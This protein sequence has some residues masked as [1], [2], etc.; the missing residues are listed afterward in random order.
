MGNIVVIGA[1]IGGIA[2]ALRLAAAGHAVTVVEADA[3][4][5][6][7]ARHVHVAGRPVDGGPTVFTLRW[8][9]DELL[10]TCGHDPDSV[11]AAEPVDL[12][13]RHAWTGGGELDLH[14]DPERSAAAI[15]NLAGTA[16]AARFR[17]FCARARKVYATLERS[18]MAAPRPSMPGLVWRVGLRGLPGLMAASPFVSMWKALGEHFHDPR[19]RQLFGRYA[20]YCGSSP[21]Q[22]PSTL[23]LVAHA[24][25]LGVWA[26]RDGM[27]GFAQRLAACAEASGARFRYGAAVSRIEVAHGRAAAVVLDDGARI[28]ADAVIANADPAAIAHGHFGEA[29]RGAVDAVPA[30]RRSLSAYVWCIAGRARGFPLARHTVFFSTDYRAEFDA[31]FGHGTLPAEP[32]VYAWAADRRDDGS[33]P[34]RDERLMFLANAPAATANPT[35]AHTHAPLCAPPHGA[36]AVGTDATCA[37]YRDRVFSLLARCGLAVD[38]DDE[39]C[40]VTTPQDFARRFPGS[41]GALYGQPTHGWRASFSRGGTRTRLP[42]LYLAGGGVHPGAG[43]PMVA[44][45]GRLAAEAVIADLERRR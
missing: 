5:G 4:P 6:G 41:A 34:D 38:H 39:S 42:G 26:P 23:M 45:S 40:V 9:F 33:A 17:A 37:A 36:S 20:T 24:E 2:S 18:F 10:A 19:L 21:W 25:Q 16:E 14:T 32:T 7:K 11:L 27:A 8:V 3:V 35:D 12:L 1:G 28:T 30:D 31:I 22:A 29:A 44:L 13:A 43:V 15:D